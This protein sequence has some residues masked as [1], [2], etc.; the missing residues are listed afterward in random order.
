MIFQGKYVLDQGIDLDD[1]SFLS[2]TKHNWILVLF[3]L[4]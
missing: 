1:K 2:F 3:Y 4:C